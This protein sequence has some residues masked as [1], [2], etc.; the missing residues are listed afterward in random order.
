MGDLKE[1]NPTPLVS[2]SCMTY[3]HAPFLRKCLD[4]FLLQKT[5]F[6]IEILIHDDASTDGTQEI[7]KEYSSR[8]PD[9][10]LPLIQEENQYSKGFR[11]LSSFYNYPRCRGKYIAICEGDDFWTDPLKL[12][13][14]VDFLEQHE[15]YVM[16]YHDFMTVDDREEIINKDPLPAEQKKDASRKDLILGNRVVMP[17]TLCFRNMIKKFPPEKYKVTNGDTFLISM[18]G[19]Y[20]LGK[21][22]GNDIEKAAYRSHSG[23]VWSMQN[24]GHKIQRQITTYYWMFRYYLRMGKAAY[25]LKWYIKILYVRLTGKAGN[26]GRKL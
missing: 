6:P 2:I 16:A 26:I 8:Y 19:Q 10:I 3:N 21:W 4:N 25:A 11:G 7:I 17:L 9:K 20:G 14:Q 23:G 13:K 18:L 22:M 1:P 15:D 12:Q 24:K 5:N